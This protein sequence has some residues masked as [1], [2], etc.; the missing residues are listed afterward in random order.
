M[1]NHCSVVLKKK[2]IITVSTFDKNFFIY[3]EIS[4]QDVSCLFVYYM[5][6]L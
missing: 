4:V 1:I 6:V 5:L 3:A 2:S